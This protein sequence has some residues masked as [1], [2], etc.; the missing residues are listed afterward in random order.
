MK[1]FF[2]ILVLLLAVTSAVSAQSLF[3][4]LSTPT[5]EPGDLAP[6]YSGFANVEPNK[7]E[8]YGEDGTLLTYQGV[9]EENYNKFGAYLE[10]FGFEATASN[11]NGRAVEMM[12]DKYISGWNRL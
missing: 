12:L 2:I 6:S 11:V 7:E 1:K 5:P 10:Q 4:L 3:P 9:T 8:A